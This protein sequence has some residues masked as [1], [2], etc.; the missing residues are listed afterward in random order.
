MKLFVRSIRSTFGILIHIK[1]KEERKQGISGTIT[2][3][4][5]HLQSPFNSPLNKCSPSSLVLSQS[6]TIFYF[7]S[8]RIVLCGAVH[9][10]TEPGRG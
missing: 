5:N 2:V 1:W 4:L 10:T 6:V 8:F 3:L 7:N 9:G